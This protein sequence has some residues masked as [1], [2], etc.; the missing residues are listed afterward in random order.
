MATKSKAVI[1]VV[2][3]AL[4][5]IAIISIVFI[6]PKSETFKLIVDFKNYKIAVEAIK[7][8]FISES[9]LPYIN[10]EKKYVDTEMGIIVDKPYNDWSDYEKLN[11]AELQKI[12]HGEKR[13]KILKESFPGYMNLVDKADFLWTKHGSKKCIKIILGS[14]IN[15]VEISDEGLKKL[16]ELGADRFHHLNNF[17]IAIFDKN[18]FQGWQEINVWNLFL[19]FFSGQQG[20]VQDLYF[21]P[22]KGSI[23]IST[24]FELTNVIIDDNE[25]NCRMIKK[26]AFFEGTKNLYCVDIS[27]LNTGSESLKIWEELNKYLKSFKISR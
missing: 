19:C 16:R 14:I 20:P 24:S 12:I 25:I 6:A 10:I 1:I 11:G 17:A 8:K 7:N 22:D 27:F 13:Y 3:A 5:A 9:E 4:V 15:G 18:S 26:V 23:L 21:D 2:I